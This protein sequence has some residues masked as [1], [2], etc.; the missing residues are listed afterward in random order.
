MKTEGTEEHGVWDLSVVSAVSCS[1]QTFACGSDCS[2]MHGLLNEAGLFPQE[3][4]EA[5]EGFEVRD[6]SVGSV[7]SC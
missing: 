4:T 3:A 2:G 6:L 7:I 1:K 5:T